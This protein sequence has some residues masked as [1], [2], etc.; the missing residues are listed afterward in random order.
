MDSR[1]GRERAWIG[2]HSIGLGVGGGGGEEDAS[3]KDG[4]EVFGK[5]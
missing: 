4:G 5:G 2:S 3:V 1:E